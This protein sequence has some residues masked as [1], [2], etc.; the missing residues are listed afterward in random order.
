MKINITR[1]SFLRDVSK[2]ELHIIHDDGLNRHIRLKG[3]NTLVQYFDLITWKGHLCYTGDMGTFVFKRLEDMFMFFRNNYREG[4]PNFGYWAEKCISEDRPDGMREYS[5][6]VFEYAI[7]N[8]RLNHAYEMR[9]YPGYK[10]EAII[11]Y[12]RAVRDD[13]LTSPPGNEAAA[14][15][16]IDDCFW[17]EAPNVEKVTL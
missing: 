2:H 16:Y 15:E 7:K 6:D 4:E 8:W 10:D 9:T 12:C 3:P 11:S 5:D 13:L 1:D 17:R 14:R